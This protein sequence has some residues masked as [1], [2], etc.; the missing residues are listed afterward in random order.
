MN[1]QR[2]VLLSVL[3]TVWMTPNAV[4][5]DPAPAQSTNGV[6]RTKVLTPITEAP[7]QPDAKNGE[8]PLV[9][10]TTPSKAA[11]PGEDTKRRLETPPPSEWIEKYGSAGFLIRQPDRRNFLELF[12]PRAPQSYGPRP[13]P[14]FNKDPNLK[15]GA[16][17]PRTFIRDGIRNEPDLK[18]YSLPF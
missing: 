9:L 16:T 6:P 1:V 12:N 15:P 17:L 14:T 2:L 18:V 3:A 10:S 11:T 4:G 13:K 8:V 7:A 5:A